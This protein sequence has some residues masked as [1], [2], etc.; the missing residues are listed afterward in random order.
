MNKKLRLV[1]KL[2]LSRLHPND[3]EYFC[4]SDEIDREV[5]RR[6]GKTYN[7]DLALN[8][9]YF[10]VTVDKRVTVLPM[11]NFDHWRINNDIFPIVDQS[12]V[13]KQAI[14]WFIRDVHGVVTVNKN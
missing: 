14:D 2:D 9:L 13:A 11:K 6:K 5:M 7:E 10:V 12:D 4:N 3:L 1:Q 8:S